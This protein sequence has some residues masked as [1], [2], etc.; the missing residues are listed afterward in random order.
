M[1]DFRINILFLSISVIIYLISDSFITNDQKYVILLTSLLVY[2][3]SSI[4]AI[5]K[6]T[7]I[8]LDPLIL[9]LI[10]NQLVFLGG[11]T[12]FLIIENGI[13]Q[14][15]RSASLIPW[16]SQYLA[17]TGMLINIGTICVTYGYYSK[18]GTKFSNFNTKYLIKSRI[19]KIHLSKKMLIIIAIVGVL[20]KL[21]LMKN[22]LFGRLLN[23]DYTTYGESASYLASQLAP[24]NRLSLISFTFVFFRYL[25]KDKGYTILFLFLV[26]IELFFA[27]IEGS[28]RP[29]LEL[30]VLIFLIYYYVNQRIKISLF[31]SGFIVLYIAFT[32]ILEFKTFVLDNQISSTDPISLIQKFS[33]YRELNKNELNETVYENVEKNIYYR[34]NLITQA[35]SAIR[36]A[37]LNKLDDKD[38]DFFLTLL[39]VPIDVVIPKSIQGTTTV[40]WGDW[41][42]YAVLNRGYY[43][44]TYSIPFSPVGYLYFLGGT[45][46]VIV[47]FFIYGIMLKSIS[48]LP[49]ISFIGFL[50]FLLLL[51]C[52]GMFE[53]AIPQSLV[54]YARYM[55]VLP[56]FYKF[57]T[58]LLRKKQTI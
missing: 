32:L 15:G 25:K 17:K 16:N 58:E 2:T 48:N 42:R 53:T 43:Y 47:G 9:S 11:F 40:N 14:P 20:I 26:S 4:I 8:L 29:I 37:D 56:F 12:S 19:S 34:I 23:P 22:G 55:F 24:L 38:P 52:I 6:R 5:Y 27:F 54:R 28:R 3:I 36:H 50:L 51:T 33:N 39:L 10:I 21:Y 13:F 57:T 41:F 1:K 35:T 7:E 31:L 45:L 44:T 18:L 46:G 49:Q 30:Y